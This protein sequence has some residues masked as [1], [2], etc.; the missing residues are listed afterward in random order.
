MSKIN[1]KMKLKNKDTYLIKNCKGIINNN[2]IT[3]VED[4]IRVNISILDNAIKMIRT[5]D[6]YKITME[7]QK[8]LTIVGKYDIKDIGILDLKTETR[9]LFIEDNKIYIEYILHI[10]KEN[11]GLNVF[12]I[13]YEAI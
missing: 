10:G 2:K 1:I 3:F 9:K 8:F 5:T 4:G 6:E 7:F 11:L 13:E 12:E